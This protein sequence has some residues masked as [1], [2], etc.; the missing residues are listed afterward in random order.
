M[1]GLQDD[2]AEARKE[3]ADLKDKIEKIRQKAEYGKDNKDSLKLRLDFI[4]EIC[5][6]V[7]KN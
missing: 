6:Q 7:K 4:K 2:L 3:I 5:E 1:F